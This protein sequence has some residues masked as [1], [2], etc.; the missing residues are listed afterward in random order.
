[1]DDEHRALGAEPLLSLHVVDE[2][3]DAPC[4]E[5]GTALPSGACAHATA[6]DPCAIGGVFRKLIGVLPLKGAELHLA[7][8]AEGDDPRFGKEDL[9]GLDGPLERA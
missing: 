5:L 3:A 4:R 2:R 1:M 9:R 6:V 8:I 7:K